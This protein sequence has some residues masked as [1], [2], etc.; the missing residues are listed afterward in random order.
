MTTNTG[1]IDHHSHAKSPRS[2]CFTIS[3]DIVSSAN[4]EKSHPTSDHISSQPI[5]SQFALPD[6]PQRRVP[7]DRLEIHLHLI[8]SQTHRL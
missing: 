2:P 1:S 8:H 3:K 6:Q 5:R 7:Y 4:G